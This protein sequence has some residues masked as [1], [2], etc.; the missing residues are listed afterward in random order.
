MNKV[1]ATALIIVSNVTYAGEYEQ[2][3]N[4]WYQ[5]KILVEQCSSEKKVTLFLQDAVANLGNAERTEANAE[6]IE[7]V[8]L[9]NPACFLSSLSALSQDQCKSVVRF[10]IRQPIFHDQE[11]IEKALKSVKTSGKSCYVS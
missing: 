3:W 4:A 9:S 7:N 11:Q 5:N 6:V 8:I 2:Y 10:F 1:L